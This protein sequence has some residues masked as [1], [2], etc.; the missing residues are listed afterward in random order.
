MNINSV[1]AT[2]YGVLAAGVVAFQVALA[3]GAPWGHLALGGSFPGKFPPSLRVVALFQAVFI[4]L[5]A[6]IVLS[7][8]GFALLSW[9]RAARWLVWVVVSVAAMALVL[10][11][12]TPSSGERTLWAPVSL[13]LLIS[14]VLVALTEQRRR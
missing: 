12:I 14:S 10:N 4:V 11:L 5:M 13:V 8:A 6:L 9:S 7:R 2:V 1:A 3:A